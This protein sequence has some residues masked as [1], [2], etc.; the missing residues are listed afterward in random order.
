MQLLLLLLL[1]GILIAVEISLLPG[2]R[3]QR[4]DGHAWAGLLSNTAGA[5]HTP[6][7]VLTTHHSALSAASELAGFRSH[8]PVDNID[9][10]RLQ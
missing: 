9:L 6:G 7:T 5:L 1:V 2:C 3:Q 4:K 10:G 8:R